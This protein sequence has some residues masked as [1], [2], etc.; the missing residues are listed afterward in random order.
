MAKKK[1][2]EDARKSRFHTIDEK[3]CLKQLVKAETELKKLEE[4]G[5]VSSKC[6]QTLKM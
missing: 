2:I 4:S 1:Q 6:F 3:K 5:M